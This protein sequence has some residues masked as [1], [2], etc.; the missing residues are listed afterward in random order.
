MADLSGDAQWAIAILERDGDIARVVVSS[1]RGD[2]ELV[3]AMHVDGSTLILFGLH[4]DGPGPGTFGLRELRR[5]VREFG[6]IAGVERVV[7]FGG[8]RTRECH[9]GVSHGQSWSR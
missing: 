5:M 8:T 6:R 4:I 7:I 3:T 2:I 9:P 1:A